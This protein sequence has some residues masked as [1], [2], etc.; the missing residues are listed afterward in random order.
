MCVE[1]GNNNISKDEY[2][3]NTW[4]KSCDDYDDDEEANTPTQ[5][6]TVT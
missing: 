4:L 1:L 2:E 5:C 3:S 6:H